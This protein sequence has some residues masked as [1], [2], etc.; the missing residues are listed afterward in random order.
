MIAH[1]FLVGLVAAALAG[2][3]RETQ[4]NLSAGLAKTRQ[5][6]VKAAIAESGAEAVALVLPLAASDKD[7]GVRDR[8]FVEL[9]RAE[10]AGVDAAI[11]EGLGSRDE[12]V[13]RVSAELLGD[14][15]WAGAGPALLEL[16]KDRDVSVRRSAAWALGQAKVA[17]ASD[18]LAARVEQ[19][20]DRLEAA[21]AVESVS[22]I[23]GAGALERLEEWAGSEIDAVR[24][25]ALRSLSF[26]DRAVAAR[27]VA[28]ALSD[29]VD[30]V[31]GGAV[32]FAAL[33]TAEKVRRSEPIGALVELLGHPRGRVV[34]R[35]LA[36][37]RTVTAME[38]PDDAA[39]WREWWDHHGETF[40]VP[41]EAGVSAGTAGASRSRVRFYGAPIVSDRVAFVIDFS[42][43]MRDPGT[44]G[45][46][47]IDGARAALGEALDAMSKNAM[48]NVI[49]FGDEPRSFKDGLVPVTKRNIRD[50]KRFVES[51]GPR[52]YTNVFDALERALEDP[53][54]DHVIL[55]SDGSPSVGRYE[56]FSRIRRHV[57][58][59]NR[60]RAASIS[61]VALAQGKKARSFLKQLAEETGGTYVER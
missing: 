60:R 51:A 42:G 27:A 26:Y 23:R 4:N 28:S 56:Y 2:V 30:D 34:A 25:Q 10:A 61:C 32:V 47:K 6:A 46:P 17:D 39:A 15:R 24:A 11:A 29:A 22:R 12:E 48:F 45:K 9:A 16:L 35:A 40:Q 21:L 50:A 7:S 52:G 54:V 38:L 5:A 37:L 1:V 53:E 36:V 33:D 41:K 31:R 58:W 18:A 13:R 3:S 43:S 14:R 57:D 19:S 8:A 49:S 55:L 20:D 59:L 44:D